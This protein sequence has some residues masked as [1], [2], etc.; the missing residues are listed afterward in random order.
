MLTEEEKKAAAE[1]ALADKAESDRAAAARAE[2][3]KKSAAVDHAD[4]L[5]QLSRRLSVLEGTPLEKVSV[6]GFAFLALAF[7][8]LFFLLRAAWR[9]RKAGSP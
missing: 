5:A 6:L 3:D 7:G 8:G 9:H 1:K 2:A 4:A